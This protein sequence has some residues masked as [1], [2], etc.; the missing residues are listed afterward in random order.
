MLRV[1]QLDAQQLSLIVSICSAA[2]L[3][4]CRRWRADHWQLRCRA[5]ARKQTGGQ[6]PRRADSFDF[7][8]ARAAAKRARSDGG[9][10]HAVEPSAKQRVT[11]VRA[12]ASAHAQQ[13]PE[14]EDSK[15]DAMK[16]DKPLPGARHGCS[17][18]QAPATPQAAAP[19][20]APP[21]PQPHD[22]CKVC[23]RRDWP[24]APKTSHHGPRCEPCYRAFAR[25]TTL[26]NCEFREQ[27]GAGSGTEQRFIWQGADQGYPGHVGSS[28][29]V[30][31]LGRVDERVVCGQAG[32]TAAR[33]SCCFS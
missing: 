10:A 19:A 25:M 21:Q 20:A 26:V 31:E 18:V 11:G 33:A 27:F 17:S 13:D 30:L 6:L 1:V 3:A 24:R 32:G 16:C 4:A 8:T 29:G 2:L 7:N 15:T 5:S 22:L 23:D 28:A 12:N 9:R 14:A